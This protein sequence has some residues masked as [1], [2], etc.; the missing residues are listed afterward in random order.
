MFNKI[1]IHL[2]YAPGSL[3]RWVGL[4][5]ILSIAGGTFASS[6]HAADR[7]VSAS[8]DTPPRFIPDTVTSFEG[9]TLDFTNPTDD[10]HNLTA[11]DNGPDGR[12][13][14]RSG[15]VDP[16]S[17]AEVEGTRFL[18]PGSYQF[19]CTLHEAEGMTG[20]YTVAEDDTRT[21]DARPAIEVGIRSSRI[22]RVRRTGEVAVQIGALPP[23]AADGVTVT[24]KRGRSILARESD[25][26]L[27]AGEL[28]GLT[29]TLEKSDRRDLVGLDG[30]RLKL[31]GSVDFG[32]PD[33]VSKLLD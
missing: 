2:F 6:A 10:L 11:L 1:R 28:R 17:T 13:L 30:V 25:L 26:A 33:R 20:I 14:F 23:T 32:A 31:L 15:N 27:G 16:F 9:G 24:L 12:P 4:A 19:V 22:A 3:M 5:V 18:S 29:M 21:P 7:T 8:S